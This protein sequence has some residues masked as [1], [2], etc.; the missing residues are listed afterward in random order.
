MVLPLKLSVELVPCVHVELATDPVRPFVLLALNV[1]LFVIVIA[2]IIAVVPKTVTVP[3]AVIVTGPLIVK[4][5][6]MVRLLVD[7]KEGAVAPL[8]VNV[9]VFV[10]APVPLITALAPFTVTPKVPLCVPLFI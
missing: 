8:M 6:D 1:P 9:P 3:P 2:P 4:F 7:E 10:T 5:P